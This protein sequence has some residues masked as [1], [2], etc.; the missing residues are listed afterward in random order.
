MDELPCCPAE[1][2]LRSYGLVLVSFSD[3]SNGV[4][5]SAASDRGEK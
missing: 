2:Q 5:Q 1:K 4:L 3:L